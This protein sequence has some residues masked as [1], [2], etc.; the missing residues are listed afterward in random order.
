MSTTTFEHHISSL[1][2]LKI[3]FA[4]V[5]TVRETAVPAYDTDETVVS[6]GRD[7]AVPSGVTACNGVA[8]MTVNMMF[9]SETDGKCYEIYH[10]GDTLGAI[11]PTFYLGR[12]VIFSTIKRIPNKLFIDEKKNV[13]IIHYDIKVGGELFP[14]IFKLP[15][16]VYAEGISPEVVNLTRMVTWCKRQIMIIHERLGNLN[17]TKTVPDLFKAAIPAPVP[18]PASLSDSLRN[19]PKKKEEKKAPAPKPA[20]KTPAAKP[21]PAK[22]V[23]KTTAAPKATPAAAAAK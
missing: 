9:E 4:D 14:A 11:N 17:D 21:V 19:A 5:K 12:N 2:V 10:T 20:V 18:K 6:C 16:K 23:P 8:S 7:S 1:G 15:E 3:T 13:T 22:T